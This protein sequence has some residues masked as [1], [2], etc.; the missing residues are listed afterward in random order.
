M[1]GVL[2]MWFAKL[3]DAL[4]LKRAIWIKDFEGRVSLTWIAHQSEFGNIAYVYPIYKVG[5]LILLPD[6]TVSGV[7]SYVKRWDYYRK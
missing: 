4:R 6:G 3:L 2:K 1:K 7:A 5:Q